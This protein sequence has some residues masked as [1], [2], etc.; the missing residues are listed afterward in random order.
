MTTTITSG[1]LLVDKPGGWTSHDVVAKVRN[2]AGGK[3]GH[4]GTLDPMATGLLVLGLG[5][6]TRLLRFVQSFPKTYEATAVFGVATDSLDADGAILD[7]TPLPVTEEDLANVIGRFTGKIHQVPPMVSARKVEGRRLYELAREGR[8]VEREAR[9]IDIYDLEI[10]DIAPSDY[11]EVQFRV[12]C[13]TGTYVR[14]LADD[15]A[16]ALGGRAHLS[17]LRRTRNGSLHIADASS[18]ETIVAAAAGGALPELV[19]T[20]S[21][22]LADLPGVVLD[23]DYVRAVRNGAVIPAATIDAPD[24]TLVRLLDADALL[25]VY[26][27]EGATVK[28]EVVTS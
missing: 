11:P 27:V 5:Q 15:M 4:A 17:A 18:I 12:M 23:P 21:R 10:L 25:G 26:R 2:L 16:R 14:T 20:P 7:R 24:G 6:S 28:A 22:A 9:P 1:F 19:I 8:I 13:S 3:V